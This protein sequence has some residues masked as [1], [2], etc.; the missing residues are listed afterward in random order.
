MSAINFVVRGDAGVAERGAIAGTSASNTIIVGADQDISL[1]L[2]RSHILSYTRQGQA[3]QITL[4]DGQVITIEGFFSPNGVA[5]NQLFIS[6]SGQLAEVELIGA[7]GNLMLAQYVDADS[8]GK[9][10]PDDALYFIEDGAIQIAGV[11]DAGGVGMLGVPLMGG[12]GGLGA[13]G[14]AAAGLAG[15]A[16]AGAGQGGSDDGTPADP[17]DPSDPSDP[18]QPVGP[19]GPDDPVDPVDPVD[20]ID[21]PLVD[22]TGGVKSVDHVVNEEDYSDGVDV[23]GSGTPGTSGQVT[24]GDVSHDITVGED[25]TWT[26]TFTTDEVEGGEYEVDVTVT[27]TNEGGSSTATDTIVIDTVAE[28]SFDASVVEADGTV[29]FAEE[30]DGVVLT[31]TTQAGSSVEVSFGGSSYQATVVGEAWTLSVDPGVF[32][33]GEYDVDITVTATDAYGNTASTSDTLNI[34]TITSVTVDTSAAG[35]DG[36]VNEVEHADGVTVNGLAQSGASVVVTLGD[37]SQTVTAMASGQWTASFDASQVPQGTLELP[38]TAVATDAAGNTATATGSVQVDTELDVAIDTAGFETDGIMNMVERTD[39]VTLNGTSD[40]G[41]SVVVEFQGASRTVTADGNGSW[42]ADFTAAEIRSGDIELDAPVVATATDAAGNVAVANG[43]VRL[44]TYVN[45]L[46][47]N[48]TVEGDDVVNNAEAAGGITLNGVVEAGS[49]VLVTVEGGGR[50]ST[51]HATVNANGEWTVDFAADDLAGGEYTAN[52]TV[53]ATDIAGNTA[54]ISDTFT[55]DRVAPD[56]PNIESFTEGESAGSDLTG[57][58]GIGI[59]N[60]VESVTLIEYEEGGAT[61]TDLSADNGTFV[62]PGTGELNFFFDDGHEV[63]NGSHIV[64]TDT[65]AAGNSQSTLMVLDADGNNTVDATAGALDGFNIGAIDLVFAE[66]TELTLNQADLEA[67][68]SNDNILVIHGS[69]D[70]SVTFDGVATANGQTEIDGRTY[71]VY[72]VGADG[73]L[74]VG[75]DIDF[76]QNV[77]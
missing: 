29:N 49:T 70:D 75:E 24:I 65:D 36:T 55:V 32:A 25:G 14:A 48:G 1:N 22:I 47:M 11:E 73:Q 64:V 31:G 57:T 5:E 44:D 23:S 20:P 76:Q 50:A 42:S 7:D 3:L 51:H 40:A 4:V 28:V 12:I 52:V 30:A 69:S 26:T 46:G 56:A 15:L 8:F 16:I 63:P 10:S 67:M 45:E 9:W 59:E 19:G 27:L 68:S 58:R 21:P 72:D 38:V 33:Q 37:V 66:Q 2:Q 35:G 60:S 74:I 53:N 18:D 62:N 54:S 39:G 71:D 13:A 17:S 43:T 77:V 61:A 41:A 34:D 6:A